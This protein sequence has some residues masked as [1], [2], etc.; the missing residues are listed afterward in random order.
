M[1]DGSRTPNSTPSRLF[2]PSAYWNEG[3]NGDEAE[4]AD[5]SSNGR[6]ASS[7]AI[8]LMPAAPRKA[9]GWPKADW[10]PSVAQ[11]EKADI[12]LVVY[13]SKTGKQ[14]GPKEHPMLRPPSAP[15]QQFGL[16]TPFGMLATRY[17]GIAFIRPNPSHYCR[18]TPCGESLALLIRM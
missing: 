1:S 12:E 18:Q 8:G 16:C 11:T 17:P 13:R 15:G 10:R 7:A 5:I 6:Y 2:R 3:W 4:L 14:L 9:Q